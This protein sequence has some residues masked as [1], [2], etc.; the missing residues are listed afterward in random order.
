MGCLT[1]FWFWSP[2]DFVTTA[3]STT[4]GVV[5]VCFGDSKGASKTGIIHY[6]D[7]SQ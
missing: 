7:I 1:V 2:L 5:S 3:C 6:F 4:S